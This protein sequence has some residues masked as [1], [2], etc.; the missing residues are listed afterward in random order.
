[1]ESY[2]NKVQY[3]PTLDIKTLF[4]G[5]LLN[6][7]P[8]LE[9]LGI[10]FENIYKESTLVFDVIM[11]REKAVTH[12]SFDLI[13]PIVYISLFTI[14]LMLLGKL[15]F[16]H[17]YLLSIS[18]VIGIYG[19]TNLLCDKYVNLSACCNILGYSFLPILIF[20]WLHIFAFGMSKA[21]LILFGLFISSWS[22]YVASQVLSYRFQIY[23]K[24]FIIGYPIFLGYCFFILIVVF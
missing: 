19:L 7:P 2:K 11:D 1:M 8:L 21:A 12:S 10:S 24:T 6:D 17:I 16:G 18:T 15:H 9:E 23:D 14:A 3:R 13:G 20:S 22:T 4:T 5:S